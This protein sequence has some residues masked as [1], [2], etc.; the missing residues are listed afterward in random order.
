[1]ADAVT[2]KRFV[3]SIKLS[4]TP[5]NQATTSMNQSI[6]LD[7]PILHH[8]KMFLHQ[9]QSAFPQQVVFKTF[10][11]KNEF[12]L[13]HF[14]GNDEATTKALNIKELSKKPQTH[15]AIM[16]MESAKNL[17][18]IKAAICRW[19]EETKT[20]VSDHSPNTPNLEFS[21]IRFLQGKHPMETFRLGL[22]D[23]VNNQIAT[24]LQKLSRSLWMAF[25]G[26][27]AVKHIW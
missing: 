15:S 16:I 24:Y 3:Y 6:N 8:I 21:W 10:D 5:K 12:D 14:I 18:T 23:N 22:Q 17:N 13:T 25:T 26:N 19:L 20:F 9:V 27:Y 4:F 2:A 1:M 11:S 7:N